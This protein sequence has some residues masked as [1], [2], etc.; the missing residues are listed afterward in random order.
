M[1]RLAAALA[2]PDVLAHDPAR[3]GAL[4][5]ALDAADPPVWA[6]RHGSAVGY[7]PGPSRRRLVEIDRRGQL[8]AVLSWRPDGS[9]AWAK[10]RATDGRWI[11]IEPGAGRYP[12][13]ALADQVWRLDPA[14]AWRPVER[15]TTFEGLDYARVDR[16][17][18]L[19]EPR[20]L[21]AGAGTALLDLLAGLLKDQGTARVRYVGPYPTEQLFT[22]LLESFRYDASATSAGS[23]A[24]PPPGV[25]ANLPLERFLAGEPVDW[26]PAPHERHEVAPGVW[27]Q[28]RHGLEKVVVDGAAF[29]RRQWQDVARVEPR[30]LREE[31]ERAICSLWALGQPIEDRLVLDRSGEVLS[32][33]APL[34][35]ARAPAPLPPVWRPALAALIARESAPPLA[36]AIAE[37]VAGLSLEWGPAPGDLVSV[38]GTRVRLARRLRDV[39]TDW[40]RAA[41]PGPPRGERAAV[42]ALEVARLLAPTA[43]LVAQIA[44]EALPEEEQLRRWEAA[45]AAGD[46]PLDASVGRLVALVAAGHA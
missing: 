38:D 18:P 8:V 29:Y 19:A 37:V 28:L 23:G 36:E 27:A 5:S 20:R 2:R 3:L 32:R 26:L 9:L 12:A 35:D 17:P 1:E 13:W 11:G 21:G 15:L 45:S 24:P 34:A 33:P 6:G 7:E 40:I 22:A 16:I 30:V 39:A 4:A 10:C 25:P 31:G 43:R 42:F 41:A 44:L 14:A 46:P